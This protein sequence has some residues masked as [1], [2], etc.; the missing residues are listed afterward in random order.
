MYQ[1]LILFFLCE[2]INRKWQRIKHWQVVQNTNKGSSVVSVNSNVYVNHVEIIFKDNTKFEKVEK[3]TR[4][5]T[6]QVNHEK[7]INEILKSLISAGTL[8]VKEYKKIKAVGSIPSVLI[9]S[10]KF[11]EQLLMFVQ[12]LD[13]YCLQ[14]CT[15]L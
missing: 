5:S 9:W 15:R 1:L 4:T 11:T 10:L 7:R 2:K 6:F 8:S 14:L 12:I 3:K 13:L